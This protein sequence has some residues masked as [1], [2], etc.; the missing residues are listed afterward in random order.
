ATG[1]Y[2]HAVEF[3]KNTHSPSPTTSHGGLRGACHAYSSFPQPSRFTLP[4]SLCSALLCLNRIRLGFSLSNRSV[5]HFPDSSGPTLI[6]IQF[7]LSVSLSDSFFRC[8]IGSSEP[9]SPSRKPHQISGFG[10]FVLVP[11]E[12]H[13]RVAVS[14]QADQRL[15]IF[16]LGRRTTLLGSFRD[17]NSL[18]PVRPAPISVTPL[19]W[20][21]APS[22][23][24]SYVLFHPAL[25]ATGRTI[26][27][28]WS[29]SHTPRSTRLDRVSR[30]AGP[31]VARTGWFSRARLRRPPAPPARGRTP[32]R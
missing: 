5:F 13:H 22:S 3:S 1:L 20:S 15:S 26:A 23:P 19:E 30:R 11:E 14:T 27:D 4:F 28:F 24:G 17:V 12:S 21:V 6:R 31:A 9:D 18:D 8:Q 32:G 25:C 2:R 7:S 16:S 29:A 10:I